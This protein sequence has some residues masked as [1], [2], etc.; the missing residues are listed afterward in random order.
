MK[1]ND[2]SEANKLRKKAEEIL[3]NIKNKEQRVNEE[4]DILKLLHEL[5]V[6][7][8][9]LELQNQELLEA[10]EETETSLQKY[11][12]LFDFA[13]TGYL[14]LS[15][16]GRIIELNLS[17]AMM[18]GRDRSA[19]LNVDF[20]SFI[21]S[22]TRPHYKQFL[23]RIFKHKS[24]ETC[25]L[26]LA[27]RSPTPISLT[28]KCEND[29]KRCRLI[30]VDLSEIVNSEKQLTESE[31]KFRQ[32]AENSP[33]II[34]RLLLKPKVR[35]DYVSPAATAITGYT[36]EDH[37]NDPDL[38]FKLVHPDDRKLLEDSTR[39][40]NGEPLILRWIKKDGTIIWTEQRNTLLFDGNNEPYAIEGQ[41]R[42]ITTSKNVEIA[43]LK[44]AQRNSLLLEL[45]ATAPS[46]TDKQLY[47]KALDIA[48]N[49]TDSK[50]GFFHQ[51]SDD[52]KEIILTTWNTEAKKNCTAVY[53]SHY[54]LE[55]AGNWADCVRQKNPVVLNDYLTSPNK[56]GLPEGH[57][58]IERIMSIPVVHDEKVMLIFGVGNRSSDY[59]DLDVIQIQ[60]VANELYKI[61]EKRK[62]E[63]ELKRIEDRWQFAVEGSN[64][65]LWDW[66]IITDDVYFSNRLKEMLGFQTEET[67]G[68]LS[69]WKDR[70]HPDDAEMV[71]RQLQNHFDHKSTDYISEHRLLCKDGSWKWILDRGKVLEW[72]DEGKPARM[73][74]THT[75]ITDRKLDENKLKESEVQYRNLANAGLALIWTSGTDK[76]CN[77]FNETWLRFTGRTLKQEMGNGWAE[78]VHPDDFDKCLQTYIS[79]F[80]KRC[81]SKWSTVCFIRAGNIGG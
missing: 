77:Y 58:S 28:G 13:P 3:D 7:Q 4:H 36:P 6:R 37:Y 22:E 25:L 80:D 62:I 72:T 35:F 14:T 59:T 56:K 53:D 57:T 52:Q 54:P 51:V 38:G 32:L 8:I 43:F 47:D 33:S 27:G 60:A 76:L 74:G 55:N 75:D 71:M 70:V 31:K 1:R 15:H 9:E 64:D 12:D 41:A 46:L 50:I 29:E 30:M 42:D 40:S 45:F 66:N 79:A 20:E 23:Q 78:G 2:E 67:E 49:I 44:E 63:K 73:V 39:Y 48:V 18:L 16:A 26:T 34:Y 17:G 69:F 65:G 10:K 68:K 21:T 24:K 5:E 19:L 11:N 81:H 61:L